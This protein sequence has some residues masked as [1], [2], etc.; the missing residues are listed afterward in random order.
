MVRNLTNLFTVQSKLFTNQKKHSLQ[1]SKESRSHN[2]KKH[3]LE[4]HNVYIKLYWNMY[5]QKIVVV[6]YEERKVCS[7]QKK[8]F[9]EMQYVHILKKDRKLILVSLLQASSK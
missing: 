5:A 4:I 7:M 6:I 3:I 8:H 2:A 1:K 9:L